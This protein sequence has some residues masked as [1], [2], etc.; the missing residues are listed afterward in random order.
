MS[1]SFPRLTE[2][3]SSRT[4]QRLQDNFAEA[5]GISAQILDVDGKELTKGRLNSEFLAS[6]CHASTPGALRAIEKQRTYV[7]ECQQGVFSF[8]TPIMV[9]GRPVGLIKGG[10]VR[11]GNPDLKE[12]K[13][14]A[15]EIGVTFD[16]YLE[17]YLSLPLFTRER[18]E[19][20]ADLLRMV[21][22]TISTMAYAG[23]SAEEEIQQVTYIN[24]LLEAEVRR[25]TQDLALVN[26]RYRSLMENAEDI[27]Y[28][29]DAEGIL[30]S[31]NS[32]V[33]R[34]IGYEREEIVGHHFKEFV[35]PEDADKMTDSFMEILNGEKVGTSGM[36][37]RLGHKKG[38][39]RWV[40]LNSR[41]I[42]NNDGE[43]VEI[44]GIL[45]DVTR[46]HEERHMMEASERK[47]R[48]LFENSSKPIFL[49]DAKK[50]TCLN[51]NEAMAEFLGYSEVSEMEGRPATDFIPSEFHE[52]YKNLV[53]QWLN[54]QDFT[55]E[56]SVVAFLTKEGTNMIGNVTFSKIT[57]DMYMGVLWHQ[58]QDRSFLLQRIVERSPHAQKLLRLLKK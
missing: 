17:A 54:T 12:C 41:G 21:A 19:A 52:E 1:S 42:K 22:S 4:L 11:L 48:S 23:F 39:Y 43:L 20:A 45:R 27:I 49:L 31:V 3:V 30:T 29:I 40:E 50:G 32:A 55:L 51:V 36:E 8:A 7:Y 2:L 46:T 5:L 47:Y 9:E 18:L 57:R 25:K 10:Q 44:E 33:T 53:Q 14:R 34:M 24:D 26:E 6:N 16:V 15:E 56:E 37:F 13:Y 58:N 38:G 35:W 28:T